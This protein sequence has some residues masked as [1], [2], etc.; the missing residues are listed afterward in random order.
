ME[1]RNLKF[2]PTGNEPGAVNASGDASPSDNTLSGR[3]NL[4]GPAWGAASPNNQMLALQKLFGLLLSGIAMGAQLGSVFVCLSILL[5]G[6][7]FFFRL[8]PA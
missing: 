7:S 3:L 2:Q 1:P 8:L 6:Y 4:A 5:A